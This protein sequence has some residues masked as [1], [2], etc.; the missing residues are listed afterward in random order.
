MTDSRSKHFLRNWAVCTAMR[1]TNSLTTKTLFALALGSLAFAGC[2]SADDS[3]SPNQSTA[4][5][6][7]DQDPSVKTVQ[8]CNG[9]QWQCKAHVVVDEHNR[10]KP[11]AVPS[12]L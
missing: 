11:N 10:I 12:G 5:D 8:V 1:L 9:G 2:V 7:A 4:N 6:G 3:Q